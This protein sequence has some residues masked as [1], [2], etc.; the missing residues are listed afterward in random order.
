MTLTQAVGR[1]RRVAGREVQAAGAARTNAT[2]SSAGT[3]NAARR[4]R[5]RHG[6][7]RPARQL[8]SLC[9]GPAE[10]FAAHN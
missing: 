8:G 5:N 3:R 2:A 9:L 4:R 6:R 7:Q 10:R 1:A